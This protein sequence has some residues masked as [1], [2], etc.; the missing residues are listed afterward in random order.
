[1]DQV[2]SW[3]HEEGVQD[4]SAGCPGRFGRHYQIQR[5]DLLAR[6]VGCQGGKSGLHRR[7]KLRVFVLFGRAATSK[8]ENAAEIAL[9]HIWA[10]TC[11]P[12]AG[13]FR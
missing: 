4:T 5:F 13:L 10:M 12:V 3:G 1:V 2:A 11:D 7:C 8:V 9:E 6:E